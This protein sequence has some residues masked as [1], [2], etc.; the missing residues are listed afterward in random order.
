MVSWRFHALVVAFAILLL[1]GLGAA[2]QSGRAPL[3]VVYQNNDF[4][5]TGVAVSKTGRLF[6]NFPRW[7]DRYLNAVVEVMPDGSTKPYPDEHWNQWDLQ[8]EHAGNQFVCVQ[9]VVVDSNDSL[10]VLDPAAPLLAVVVPGGPKLVKI[11]LKTDQVERIIPFGSDVVKPGTYLNDVRFDVARHTAYLTDSG[12]GG[13]IVLDLKTGKARRLLDGNPSVLV[14]PGVQVVVDGKQLLQYGK[15]PQF[16]SDGL[17]L[18]PDGDYLYYKAITANT[19]YRIATG[20]LRDPGKSPAQVS[21]AVEKVGQTFPADG[22]WFDQKGNL[23]LSDVTHNAVVRRTLN[24]KLETVAEDQRLQWPDSFAEGPDG[25]LYISA[26]HIN[27]SP[28]FN[29]GK[30]VRTT[31]YGVFKF[32]P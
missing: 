10:W 27:E 19:L 22:L 18:S 17:A 28:Q 1:P 2:Q 24:G 30:S 8:A 20:V 29:Q 4:Q 25:S 13:I 21:A 7:S 12:L 32:K 6:V 9:S 16:K 31:P 3:S 26:S 11:N 23:Y 15:P 14:E 5:L